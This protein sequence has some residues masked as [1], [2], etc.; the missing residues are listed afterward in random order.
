MVQAGLELHLILLDVHMPRLSGL[1]ALE[2]IREENEELLPCILM[3]AQLDEEIVRQ[4]QQLETASVMSKPFTLRDITGTVE[5]ILRKSYG[6][7][8]S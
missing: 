6:W 3:S 1:Q 7:G 5:E 8:L 4:A 2:R